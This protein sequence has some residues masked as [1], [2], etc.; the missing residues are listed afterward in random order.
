MQLWLQVQV[1]IPIQM[2]KFLCVIDEC[3]LVRSMERRY[4]GVARKRVKCVS[5]DAL[6]LRDV[7]PKRA[8]LLLLLRYCCLSCQ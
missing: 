4:R 3:H 5:R 7:L 8:S 1:L 6:L 2:R